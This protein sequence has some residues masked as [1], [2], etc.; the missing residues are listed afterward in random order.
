MNKKRIFLVLLL[1]PAM[2]FAY[3]HFIDKSYTTKKTLFDPLSKTKDYKKIID[4]RNLNVQYVFVVDYSIHSGKKR[5]YVLD[6][7]K[8]KIVK[9]MMVAHGD[10]SETKSGYATDF[11]NVSESNKSS[12]GYAVVNGRAYSNW[13]IHVKYW[14]DGISSTN[15]NMRKR[16]MVLHSYSMVPSYETY[17]LPIVT[18]LGCVMV[19]KTDMTYLDNLIKKQKNKKILMYIYG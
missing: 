12:L 17:P 5:M 3:Y 11:S 7:I 1:L 2:V 13:G 9:K 18:S 16:V 8:Q 15:S 10:K 19:S 6:I 14:L 4:K